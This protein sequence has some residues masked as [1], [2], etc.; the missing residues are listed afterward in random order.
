[1]RKNFLGSNAT[2]LLVFLDLCFT[3]GCTTKDSLFL[4]FI[5]GHYVTDNF[6]NQLADLQMAYQS[7]LK[8]LG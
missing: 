2:L 7:S 4:L 5:L 6:Q 3:V 8:E 1:M